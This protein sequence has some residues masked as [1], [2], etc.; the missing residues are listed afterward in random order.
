VDASSVVEETCDGE[1]IGF[2]F[3]VERTPLGAVYEFALAHNLGVY[4]DSAGQTI[5]LSDKLK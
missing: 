4:A 3:L 1:L 2:I 5:L